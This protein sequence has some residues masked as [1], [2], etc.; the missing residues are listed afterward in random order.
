[1]PSIKVP[2]SSSSLFKSVELFVLQLLLL[3]ACLTVMLCCNDFCWAPPHCND[4]SRHLCRPAHTVAAVFASAALAAPQ[5]PC[6]QVISASAT[7]SRLLLLQY[8]VIATARLL[9]QQQLL[10]SEPQE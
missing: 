1:V 4:G 10:T 6:E 9:Q 3:I 2:K 5:I 8:A 7:S